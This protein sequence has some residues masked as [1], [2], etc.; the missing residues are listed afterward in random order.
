MARS[1]KG[2][3]AVPKNYYVKDANIKHWHLLRGHFTGEGEGPVKGLKVTSLKEGRRLIAK[4]PNSYK[5]A[6]RHAF[7]AVLRDQRR[8]GYD[9]HGK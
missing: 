6:M 2:Y 8:A 9:K 5:A 3:Y 1:A 4:A 7:R